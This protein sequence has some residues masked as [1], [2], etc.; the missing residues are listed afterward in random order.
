MGK[1]SVFVSLCGS[2]QWH[3]ILWAQRGS[4]RIFAGIIST[5]VCTPT[6]CTHRKRRRR[7]KND[8]DGGAAEMQAWGCF[9]VYISSGSFS[10]LKF[11]LIRLL[12]CIMCK[13]WTGKRI[14]SS[15]YMLTQCML[16]VRRDVTL[17]LVVVCHSSWCW[18]GGWWCV[19]TVTQKGRRS[20]HGGHGARAP[21]LH[22]SKLSLTLTWLGTDVCYSLTWLELLASQN[23]RES[24][25]CLVERVT[26]LHRQIS[27]K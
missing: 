26:F 17:C 15:K 16:T 2:M 7:M 3:C 9:S 22:A 25:V 23:W 5:C 14:N 13:V 10:L 19:G 12:A 1:S 11:T 18:D 27:S 20:K 4:G 24:I 21:S 6:V 8:E